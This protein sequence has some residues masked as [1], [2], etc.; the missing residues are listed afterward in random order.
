MAME[1][2]SDDLLQAFVEGQAPAAKWAQVAAHL[3][4]CPTCRA[5]VSA[6]AAPEVERVGRYLITRLL[7]SGA[8]GVVFAAYDPELGRPVAVKLLKRELG[9]S[10]ERRLVEEAQALARLS[11]PN[12]VAV[13]DVGH[14]GGRPF[15]V[16]DLVEG[17]SL[18]AWWSE[19]PRSLEALTGCFAQAA[20][21]LAAAHR[22]GLVH[23]DF[24]PE[25]VLVTSD[26]Q[27]RVTDFGLAITEGAAAA[28]AEGS[29]AYMAPEQASGVAVDA[30]SDQY[31]FFVSLSEAVAGRRLPRW[32]RDALHRGLEKDPAARHPSM[33]HVA[34]LLEDGPAR[35][36]RRQA[37]ALAATLGVFA[38]SWVGLR[39]LEE[40]S[41]RAQCER[42]GAA[43]VV[44][45]DDLAAAYQATH[46]PLAAHAWSDA[47][48]RL[49]DFVSRWRAASVETCR[50]RLEA[51]GPQPLLEAQARCLEHDRA[52]LAAVVAALRGIDA[53]MV[54]RSSAVLA[55][56]GSVARCHDVSSL[57]LE[58]PA[59][60]A[61]E[62]VAEARVLIAGG[63]YQRALEAAERAVDSA[64]REGGLA[65]LGQALLWRGTAHGRLGQL[66]RAQADLEESVSAS[67]A[68]G[69]QG[70]AAEG[71][72]RLMQ[73]VGFEG[74]QV[75]Q[76]LKYDGYARAAV[77]RLSGLHELE[78]ERLGWRSALLARER[79]FDEALE[80]AQ[81][82]LAVVETRLGARHRLHAVALD[83]LAGAL[84]GVGRLGEAER[85]QREACQALEA[86]VGTPHPRLAACLNNLGG[87]AAARG[88][89]AQAVALRREALSMLEKMPGPPTQRAAM[90]R[91]LAR[92]LDA[93]GRAEE[94]ELQRRAAEALS[95]DAGAPR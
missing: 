90:H 2:P 43:L 67:S 5:C 9:P 85:K 30:R 31:A 44:P 55:T 40:R 11:H 22:A 49:E 48:G 14:E 50:A 65:A 25:N 36:R 12:V 46:S 42:D 82:Q 59:F 17:Q 28:V 39:A 53:E 57:T 34:R 35:R 93:L 74:G 1:C 95:P 52:G 79:R 20:A 84:A 88:D 76:G 54:E 81:Q 83:S 10:L 26:N 71:W 3:D 6:A 60:A 15:V 56:L 80:A 7:G 21:G 8:M 19:A 29:P 38:L 68:A 51:R 16:M 69:A 62:G 75:D 66:P 24:K 78:A 32:L 87:L 89:W 4:G 64:R 70:A 63:R 47:R 77:E 18:R 45:F 41:I 58:A 33:A 92:A 86:E 91:N 23:R 73:F 27:V 72:V 61:P 37:L 13:H 94:A